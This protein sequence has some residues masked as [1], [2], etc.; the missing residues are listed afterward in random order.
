MTILPLSKD[1]RFTAEDFGRFPGLFPLV[2]LVI[3]FILVLFRFVFAAAGFSNFTSAILVVLILVIL[4]R[5]FHLDG[6]ADTFDAL[7]SHRSQDEKLNILKDPHQGTFGVLAIVLD[8]LLKVGLLASLFEYPNYLPALLL[9]PVWGRFSTSIVTILSNYAR[10]SGGLGYYMVAFSGFK[11]FI[12]AIILA[13]A[14]SLLSGGLTCLLGAVVAIFLGF[15]LTFVWAKTLGGVTGDLLGA[16][17]ELSE[18]T[19]LAFF[20]L[21][22]HLSS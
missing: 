18:I 10:P 5:G 17:T 13:V 22:L 9:F 16:T 11:D 8:I 20:Q 14:I 6:I 2:G 19:T 15:F 21:F 4:T 1:K 3:G 7:L 12:L